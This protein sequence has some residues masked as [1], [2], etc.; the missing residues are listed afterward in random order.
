MTTAFVLSG[1]GNL[2]AAQAGMLL[3][4]EEAGIRPDLVV[5][6]SVGALNGAWVAA[7]RPMAELADVWTG[8]RR[9][10]V[11]PY[12]PIA[13]FLGFSRAS[14]HLVPNRGLRRLLR[15]HLS[16]DR[17]EDAP[18]SIH[19]IATDVLTGQDVRLDSGDATNAILASSAIPS[20][21][22]PVSVGGRMLMDGGVVNNA[23]ISHAVELGADRV[24][25]LATGYACALREPPGSALG[26]GLHALSLAIQQRLAL[27]VRRYASEYD[28]RVVPPLCPI[29]V[30]PTD[31]SQSASLIERAG[32]HTGAW[33]ESVGSRRAVGQTDASAVLAV[34]DH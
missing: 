12:E 27:D 34:H 23:P 8:L 18:T 13:G 29:T 9:A 16:F 19:V 25:V 7:E 28:V 2:G 14:N 3:A 10:D 5:G 31:F 1:G 32:E 22:P 24:W 17:L 21:F 6:T 20:V 4:F 15:R 26:M 30:P 11:F 33:L